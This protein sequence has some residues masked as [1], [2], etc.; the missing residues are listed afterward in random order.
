MSLP[1]HPEPE[2]V[3]IF[4]QW[5]KTNGATIHDAVHFEKNPSGFSVIAEQDVAGNTTI[6]SVPSTL[7]ITPELALR[8]LTDIIPSDARALTN[9]LQKWSER[10]LMCSYICAHWLFD[11]KSTPP[12]LRHRPY[13]NMLPTHDLLRT[14][15][16]FTPPELELFRGSNLYGAT[17]DRQKTWEAEWQ[18]CRSVF[19]AVDVN[20]G[21]SLSWEKYSTAATYLSSRAFPSSLLTSHPSLYP[22]PDSHP[23]LLPG[24]DSLNH[25][26][27]HP[28]SWIVTDPSTAAEPKVSLVLHKP[29]ERGG[30]LLNNYGLKP[31]AELILGYGFSLLHNPDDTIVLKI[32]GSENNGGKGWEVGRNARG[33][34]PVWQAVLDAVCAGKDEEDQNVGVEDE[35]YAADMLGEMAQGLYNRLPSGEIPLDKEVRSDVAIMLEHYLEGQRNI[36]HSIIEFASHKEKRAVELAQEQGL[37]IVEEGDDE[38]LE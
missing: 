9:S 23:I 30:E 20:W 37:T 29:T 33:I 32:G 5:L 34:E 35:L 14:A 4:K 36:L 19:S 38:T 1:L 11:E 31:N 24:I 13:I 12:P 21:V 2:V 3:G 26:R 25:A 28:V 16:H 22:T 10:Q 17:L 8:A 15:L 7:A 18:Q 27:G 6:V